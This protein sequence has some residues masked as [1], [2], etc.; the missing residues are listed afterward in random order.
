MTGEFVDYVEPALAAAQ[1]EVDVVTWHYYP[2]QSERCAVQSRLAEPEVML[3]PAA[4]DEIET[5]A[6]QVEGVRDAH[7]AHGAEVWI[8]ETGNAQCG[9]QP[10]VSDSWASSFWWVDQLGLLSRRGHQGSIRQTLSGA[11]YALVDDVD[12][13]PNP[14]WWASLLWTQRMGPAVLDATSDDPMLRVWAHCDVEGGI[15]LAAINLDGTSAVLELDPSLG[16]WAEVWVMEAEDLSSR[17]VRINGV[18]A[19]VA[20]DGTAPTLVPWRTSSAGVVLPGRSIGFVR[21]PGGTCG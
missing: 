16:T 6:G 11:D 14:D 4:L 18:D 19:A 21:L 15:A 12:L 1:G 5:W 8:G 9:G 3:D 7:A 10:G 13:E 20:D 2:Q 17:T